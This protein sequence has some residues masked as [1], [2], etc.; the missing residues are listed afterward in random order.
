MEKRSPCAVI[1][2]K[3]GKRS[4]F[5]SLLIFERYDKFCAK[6]RLAY[7]TDLRTV[8]Q[9]RMLYNGKAETSPPD[10][11][12]MAFIYAIKA[13]KNPRNLVMRDSNTAVLDR[14]SYSIFH[15]R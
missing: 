10:L 7:D 15:T 1:F 14:Q 6:V 5:I 13:F 4:L 3:C 12:G 11:I 9:C 8:K 2:S